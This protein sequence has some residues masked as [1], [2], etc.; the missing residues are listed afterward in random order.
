MAP[1]PRGGGRRSRRRRPPRA[2]LESRPARRRR[3]SPRSTPSSSGGSTRSSRGTRAE[4]SPTSIPVSF[5]AG[6]VSFLAPCVLP[7]VPGYLSAVSAV[8]ADKL[9]QPGN[10]RRVVAASVPFVLGFTTFFVL[11][12]AGAAL[13]GGRLFADQFLLERI[14]GFVLVVFGLALMGLLPWPE[15]LLGAGLLDGAREPG[16]ALSPRGRLRGVRR[17][18]HRPG[19][20]GDPRPRRIVGHGARGRGAARGLLA[21]AGGAVRAR[22]RRLLARDGRVPVAPRPLPGRSRWS[23]AR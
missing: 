17:A 11:L 18:V 13:V 3:P 10:A 16:L 21:R 8:D 14:A 1:A 4:M 19:A 22:R 5:L 23:A 15:R 20:R 12:G 2:E 9:G 6:F 7:L